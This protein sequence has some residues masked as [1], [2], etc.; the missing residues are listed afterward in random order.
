MIDKIFK[1]YLKVKLFPFWSRERVCHN[2]KIVLVQSK[3]L[4]EFMKETSCPVT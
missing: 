1:H 3:N 2:T 4:K